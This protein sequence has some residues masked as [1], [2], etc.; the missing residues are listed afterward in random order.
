MYNMQSSLALSLLEAATFCH[1][2]K[3]STSGAHAPCRLAFLRSLPI[4]PIKSDFGVGQRRA[5][6]GIAFHM[7][8]NKAGF[9]FYSRLRPCHSVNQ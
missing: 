5:L 3:A 7:H 4:S 2:G 6:N 8:F 1:A 9:L